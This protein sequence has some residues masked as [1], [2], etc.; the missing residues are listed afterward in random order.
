MRASYPAHLILLD[1]IILILF[2]EE[3]RVRSSLLCIREVRQF[4]DRIVAQAVSCLLLTA[5]A[6]VRARVWSCWIYGGQSGTGAGFLQV[7]R[8]PLPNIPSTAP[9]S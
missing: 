8:F 6:W 7:L 3:A 9:H 1:L 4:L 5:A 2:A